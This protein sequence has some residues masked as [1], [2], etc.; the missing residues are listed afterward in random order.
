MLTPSPPPKDPRRRIRIR[1]RSRSACSGVERLLTSAPDRTA[2]RASTS[3]C[4]E[5][6]QRHN[7]LTHIAPTRGSRSHS[8]PPVNVVTHP[9][10]RWRRR[11]H[12]RESVHSSL[13]RART[14]EANVSF[15]LPRSAGGSRRVCT[16]DAAR[17]ASK[18]RTNL[19]FCLSFRF[20]SSATQKN[21]G[22]KKIFHLQ[23]PLCGVVILTSIPAPVP[24]SSP[25]IWNAP[26]RA[27]PTPST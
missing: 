10:Q 22:N 23:P 16:S 17:V 11:G 13:A 27:G 24:T 18:R 3:A 4:G 15:P 6:S 19:S 5:W 1:P 25:F 7:N 2:E 12:L 9:T 21:N 14:I 26:R 8:T 20:S